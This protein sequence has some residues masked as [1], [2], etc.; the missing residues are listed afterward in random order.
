MGHCPISTQMVSS[1]SAEYHKIY[2][3]WNYYVHTM[4]FPVSDHCILDIALVQ[5]VSIFARCQCCLN[6]RSEID[7]F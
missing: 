7:V 3:G 6:I 4:C 2:A 5:L 1:S